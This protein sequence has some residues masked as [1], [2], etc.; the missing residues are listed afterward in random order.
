MKSLIAKIRALRT[1][2]LYLVKICGPSYRR[3]I[4]R[5]LTQS[6]SLRG[7]GGTISIPGLFTAAAAVLTIVVRLIILV[8]YFSNDRYCRA[9]VAWRPVVEHRCFSLNCA[10][11]RQYFSSLIV[12]FK[13]LGWHWCRTAGWVLAYPALYLFGGAH[14]SE[15]FPEIWFVA[16]AFDAKLLSR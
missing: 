2:C 16:G 14:V 9:E 15:Q 5:I 12:H 8:S 7:S 1:S 6:A 4:A 13:I 11:R 3:S 10:Q